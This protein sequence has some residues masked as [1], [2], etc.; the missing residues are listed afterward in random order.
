MRALR[1]DELP[2]P[3]DPGPL[4]RPE[5]HPAPTMSLAA[6][7]AARNYV[8]TTVAQF[9]WKTGKLPGGLG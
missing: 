7:R 5:S 1:D 9:R 3:P 4:G 6:E 8:F 2:C